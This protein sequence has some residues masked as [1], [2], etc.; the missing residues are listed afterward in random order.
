MLSK[1]L[2]TLIV[3]GAAVFAVKRR[4]LENRRPEKLA[5]A[6]TTPAGAAE[7]AQL[8]KDLKVGAYLFVAFIGGIG[9]V[10]YYFDWQDDHTVL[11]IN[12]I[13]DAQTQ[14]VTYL[15][16]KYQLQDKSFITIDG[17]TV[18]VASNERMEIEG[19]KN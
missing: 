7:K 2:I 14:P 1:L 18:T 3:I 15:V 16:Y 4:Q 12:L 17:K 9:A 8:N 13:R 6:K 5:V 10:L 11:T 19:L